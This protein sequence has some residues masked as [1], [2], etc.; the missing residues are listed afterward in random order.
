V[1]KVVKNLAYVI[2]GDILLCQSNIENGFRN[3]TYVNS[4]G[5]TT[6]GYVI[7]NQLQ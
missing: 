5:D 6:N 7:A 2:K 4:K 3:C 1:Q